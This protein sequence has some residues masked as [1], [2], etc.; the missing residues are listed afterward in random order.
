MVETKFHLQQESEARPRQ[1]SVSG[2]V[3]DDNVP[4]VL[5]SLNPPPDLHGNI[6]QDNII[7]FEPNLPI[8][9]FSFLHNPIRHG[10][11]SGR[12]LTGVGVDANTRKRSA[13]VRRQLTAVES[14]T[15]QR[16]G[17]ATAS[18]RCRF[19]FVSILHVCRIDHRSRVI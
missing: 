8:L 5:E 3:L 18:R 6:S 19:V 15:P 2:V 11:Q 4:D 10:P 12:N 1:R 14:P 16:W 9:S 13:L 7:A 17:I